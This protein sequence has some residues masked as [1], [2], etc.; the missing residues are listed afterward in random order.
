MKN[1]LILWIFT[2]ILLITS[3]ANGQTKRALLIGIG[4]YP[5]GNGWNNLSSENDLHYLSNVLRIKGF[6]QEHITLLRNESATRAGIEKAVEDFIRTCKPGDAVMLHFSGH[7]QQITDDDGD[8]ADGY[9]EAWVPYDAKARFDPVEYRG[10]RHIRDDQIG[11]WVD[12]LSTVVGSTGTVLVNIDACHSGTA[13]RAQALAVARGTPTPFKLPGGGAKNFKPAGAA[14]SDFLSNSNIEKANVVVFSASSPVQIN[15]ET[16]DAN[17]QGV[18][19]LSYGFAKALASLPAGATYADLFYRV[20][21]SIQANLPDQSPMMEGNGNQQLFA[22]QYNI[23]K[24]R[25]FIDRWLTDSSFVL[26]IGSL[27]QWA[28]GTEIALQN[29][30]SKER[31][32]IAVAKSVSLVETVA[33][34]KTPLDKSKLWMAEV[35]SFPAPPYALGVN[36]DRNSVPKNWISQLDKA[37]QD[38]GF[39]QKT[40]NPD[41]WISFAADSGLLVISR[42]NG[43]VYTDSSAS[44]KNLNS[45]IIDA[46]KENLQ[47]IAKVNYMRNLPDGGS[48]TE[49][50]EWQVIP[51]QKTAGVLQD[52]IFNEE[53][54]FN[55]RLKNK[56]SKP[57]FF[58]LISILPDGS[59]EVLLPDAESAVEDFSI[60]PGE[61]FEITDNSI[62]SNAPKGREF[63]R[64][65]VSERPFDI[66]PVFNKQAKK[67]SGNL[68]SWEQAMQDIMQNENASVKKT[69][70]I[71]VGEITLLTQSFLVK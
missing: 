39:T 59:M 26:P 37:L 65:M 12:A 1:K 54:L 35:V 48:L 10:D 31:V 6:Q 21:A 5:R 9:D 42:S 62:G 23:P 8:E 13:T 40:D 69:R 2:A 24:N 68:S 3:A 66:R 57:V 45:E 34:I 29:P 58:A 60:Q 63:L 18:G 33:I 20:K 56:G 41:C 17:Q 61:T 14:A 52:L 22:G 27:Q 28:P 50:L 47:Q 64:V 53:T 38:F 55:I 19:S 15:Y 70:S 4:N 36:Y 51:N 25:L 44:G 7:G 43:V 11:K 67:R 71:G 16:M 46:L 32:A 30:D 49:T